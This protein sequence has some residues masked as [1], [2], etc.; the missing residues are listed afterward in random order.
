MFAAT[1]L[2]LL[3]TENPSQNYE[4]SPAIWDHT[5]LA[6]TW[7]RWTCRTLTPARQ[8]GWNSM[9]VMYLNGW[10]STD[11]PPVQVAITW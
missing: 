6:A 5:V 2:L 4:V 1:A 9:L 11:S 8:T 7:H 10:L 3:L